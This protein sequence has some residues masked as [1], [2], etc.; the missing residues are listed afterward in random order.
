MQQPYSALS[1]F[2]EKRYINI[3]YYYY[4]LQKFIMVLLCTIRMYETRQK[5]NTN[6]NDHTLLQYDTSLFMLTHTPQHLKLHSFRFWQ[7]TEEYA[8]ETNENKKQMYN[9]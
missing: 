1:Y 9:V 4:N 6:N 7:N 8:S 5:F 2:K 3:Y